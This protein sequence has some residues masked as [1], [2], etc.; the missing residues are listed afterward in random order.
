VRF[1]LE[2]R[3]GNVAQGEG[4]EFKPQYCKKKKKKKDSGGLSMV[5]CTYNF[6]YLGGRGSRIV[7]SRPVQAKL[8]KFYLKNKNKRIGAVVQ[9]VECLPTMD[10]ALGS[11]P[12][13]SE[14]KAAG[15]QH[16]TLTR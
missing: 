10:K 2:K 16:K 6:S 9:V 1:Y 15:L 11:M 12:S 4:L 5:A 13:T 8:A 14:K 3:V 7:S